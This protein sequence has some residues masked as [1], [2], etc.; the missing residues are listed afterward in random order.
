MVGT[1]SCCF[2]LL[3]PPFLHPPPRRPCCC[4]E[5]S[6]VDRLTRLPLD[7]LR[8]APLPSEEDWWRRRDEEEVRLLPLLWLPSDE[9]D[10]GLSGRVV[11]CCGLAWPWEWCGGASSVRSRGSSAKGEPQRAWKADNSNEEQA[12]RQADRPPGT[13]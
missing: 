2:C 3:L 7:R 8:S 13:K 1:P 12:G 6:S 5:L 10:D 4:C 11:W 9:W